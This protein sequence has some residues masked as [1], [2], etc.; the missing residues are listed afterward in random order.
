MAKKKTVSDL[1]IAEPVEAVEPE[2][3]ETSSPVQ[4]KA[5]SKV[6]KVCEKRSCTSKKGT[7]KPGDAVDA[8][9]FEGG[10]A[11]VDKLVE[12]GIIS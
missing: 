4:A 2:S 7:L 3:E 8:S 6:F 5:P 9:M 10:Q 1:E 11:A 12:L